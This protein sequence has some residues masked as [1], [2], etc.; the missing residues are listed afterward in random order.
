ME[1][2]Y[3]FS[4]DY[5][6][7]SDIKIK[8]LLA[9][10]GYCGYGIFWA[11]VEDLYSNENALPLDYETIAFDL[12]V[13]SNTLQSVV[14]DFGLFVVANN[15]ISSNSVASRLQKR[16]EKSDKA[17]RSAKARWSQSDN[18][19]DAMR[20]H[21]EGNAIKERKGK[22]TKKERIGQ[23][24][25]PVGDHIKLTDLH[26]EMLCH[27]YKLNEKQ[28]HEY[29]DKVLAYYAGIGKPIKNLYEM[30]RSWII[31]DQS[32]DKNKPAKAD[33]PSPTYRKL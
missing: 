13:D 26:V 20:T 33:I 5:G 16:Q 14:E 8:K 11:L 30:V 7:R 27:K 9:K 19:A 29:V 2:S 6:S 21:N 1:K 10:H 22:E 32:Q 28:V 15:I 25:S 18:K 4:H 3:Y 12:R 31:K 17:K 24:I 23:E